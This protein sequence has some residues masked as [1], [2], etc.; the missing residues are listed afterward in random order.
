MKLLWI[1]IAT[2]AGAAQAAPIVS[3]ATIRLPLPGKTVSAGYL[4]IENPDDKTQVLVKATSAQFGLI[5]LHNHQQVDGM[6][7]MV[8][9]EQLEVPPHSTLH[10][11]PGGY[12][13]MLFRPTA[14]LTPQSTPELRLTW[15]DGSQSIVRPSVTMIPKQ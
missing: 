14:P 8:K 15:S 12:H 1:A 7:R 2:L 6:L 5:E 9:V 13:L 10:L 3:N 4:S 11:Q